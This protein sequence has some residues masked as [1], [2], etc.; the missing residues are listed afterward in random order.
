MIPAVPVPSEVL[1]KFQNKQLALTPSNVIGD[2]IE[3][4][5]VSRIPLRPSNRK[6]KIIFLTGAGLSADSGMRTFRGSDGLY[7]GIRGEDLMSKETLKK[8]PEL[9][10]RFCDDLRVDL[11][12]YSPNP[13]HEMIARVQEAYSAQAIH[14]TQNFDDLNERAG[15]KDVVHLHGE[16]RK[17]R[18]NGNDKDVIDI[19]YTRYWDGPVEQSSASGFQFRNKGNALYR[20]DVI[21]FGE[22]APQ[23]AKLNRAFKHIRRDDLLIVIGTQGN[24]LPVDWLCSQVDCP[25]V[26]VNLHDS[27]HINALRF[28]HCF[29][30]QASTAAEKVE[31][32]IHEHVERIRLKHL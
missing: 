16:M 1:Q 24:V 15:A 20:T 27:E 22:Y 6:P 9:V 17:L 8:H 26:L 4:E 19:G 30:E 21:L 12:N 3:T 13:A 7:N 10:H 18:A 14:L 28:Q 25:K 32:L 2:T 29:F 11:G 23:Y 31:T 5:H